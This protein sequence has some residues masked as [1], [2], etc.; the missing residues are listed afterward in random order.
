MRISFRLCL[1]LIASATSLLLFVACGQNSGGGGNSASSSSCV[2]PQN[3]STAF[4]TVLARTSSQAGQKHLLIRMKD[5]SHDFASLRTDVMSEYQAE[6][7]NAKVRKVSHNTVAVDLPETAPASKVI[8]QYI[9]DGKL[10]YIEEDYK[11]FPMDL[12]DDNAPLVGSNDIQNLDPKL[13]EQAK[14]SK[15]VIVAIIDSGV[16]YTHKDLAPYMWHNPGEIPNNGIDD[17]GNGFI[18]DYY[19]WDFANNDNDP[20]A[21]D[22]AAYHGTHV[23]GI[24]KQAAQLAELGVNVKIMALKY[25]DANASGRTSNAIQAIDYA[26]KNGATVLNNSW[27]S[28]GSSAALSDAVERARQAN[29]L[30]IAAAGNG[31]AAGNGVNIDQTPFYPAAFPHSNIISVAAVNSSNELAPWSNFGKVGV[32]IAAPGV[33]IVSTRNGNTYGTLSG[34][35]MASPYVAGVAAM[36]WSLR[37]DLS[38]IEVKKV[39]FQSAVASPSVSGKV[40][41]NG[42]ISRTQATQVVN[43]Y[44]HNPSDTF[45]SD[46]FPGDF[47]SN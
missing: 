27:G 11:T 36:L 26:I 25:L 18:D 40:V 33:G 45:T 42:V 6:N 34:T 8:D 17:D 13:L 35:S 20:M 39:L 10:S 22:K 38:A 41:T 14:S 1:K 28:F 16:D 31:D 37:S 30:F 3:L 23:A 2:R 21:D 46:P 7:T 32:D 19:G 29:V 12:G 43:A 4:Q 15:E 5:L 47:C 44:T 9:A 24:V